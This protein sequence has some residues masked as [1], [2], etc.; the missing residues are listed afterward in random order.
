M[1]HKEEEKGEDPAGDGR[2]KGGEEKGDCGDEAEFHPDERN[3]DEE[4]QVQS[5]LLCDEK[6]GKEKGYQEETR[7]DDEKKPQ[8]F[9]QE[10]FPP[11]HGFGEDEIEGLFLDLLVDEAGSHKDGNKETKEGDGGKTQ[12]L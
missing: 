10:K 6:D 11:F 9:S 2:S 3:R 12:Y 5:S 8:V 1:A 4:A 7:C